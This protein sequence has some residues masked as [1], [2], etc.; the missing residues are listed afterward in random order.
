VN[1]LDYDDDIQF[2][3]MCGAKGYRNAESMNKHSVCR[4]VWRP[5]EPRTWHWKALYRN[6][7]SGGQYW[8]L[9][10][11]PEPYMYTCR[12]VHLSRLCWQLGSLQRAEQ[13]L[14][15]GYLARQSV[16]LSIRV[17]PGQSA[18]CFVSLVNR[19]LAKSV[20]KS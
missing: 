10:A 4:S 6:K 18:L 3:R 19:D 5:V 13:L 17:T 7:F 8:T 16:K 11:R 15:L 2:R 9:V 14:P 12:Q 20:N 1:G